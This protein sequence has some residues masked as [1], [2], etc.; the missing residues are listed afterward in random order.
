[1]QRPIEI[2]DSK[3]RFVMPSAE[4]I[5]ALD[6]DKQERFAAVQAA[7]TRLETFQASRKTPKAVSDALAERDAADADLRRLRPK[8]TQVQ[9]A[10]DVIASNRTQ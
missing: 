7:A 4:Q 3:G 6:P 10:K 1:M 5:A 8:I 9:N 2:Y